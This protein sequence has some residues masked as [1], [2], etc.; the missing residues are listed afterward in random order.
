MQTFP[1]KWCV[2]AEMY[3]VAAVAILILPLKW[4]VAWI[5]AVAVHEYAHYVALRMFGVRVYAITVGFSG[6][7]MET[8]SMNLC[9]ETVCALAGPLGGLSL[10]LF[11]RQ[12]PYVAICALFQSLYNLLPILPLDGGRV[13]LG[14]LDNFSTKEFAGKIYNVIKGTLLLIFAILSF[15]CLCIGLGFLP[16]IFTIILY[17]KSRK[18][19]PLAN[20]T[21]K[22]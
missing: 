12:M 15:I 14:L 9:E 10:L 3:F 5:S 13:L 22:L 16:M 18:E 1:I 21:N 6:A 8:D 2:R 4:V 11:A 20:S 19:I 7:V 17:L